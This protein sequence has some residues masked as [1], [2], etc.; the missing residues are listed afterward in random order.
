MAK[1]E[2]GKKL[3]QVIIT[4]IRQKHTGRKL[5]QS[6]VT[7]INKGIEKALADVK[8]DVLTD[9]RINVIFKKETKAIKK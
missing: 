9:K 8:L 3:E 6:L 7:K 1:T 4:D 5:I 2:L